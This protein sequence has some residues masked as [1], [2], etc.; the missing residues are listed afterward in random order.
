MQTT[1][2][3]DGYIPYEEMVVCSNI[4]RNGQVA[5][6]VDHRPIFLIGKDSMTSVWLQVPTGKEWRYEIIKGESTDSAYRVKVSDNSISIYFGHHL[7]LRA[8]KKS[9]AKVVIDHID[10]TRFG[11]SIYGD[12]SSL[13]VGTNEFRGNVFEGVGTMINVG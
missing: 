7:I 2:L 1:Q 6:A 5:I 8:E 3:P 4:I 11:L 9:D 12:P 10:L 13:H